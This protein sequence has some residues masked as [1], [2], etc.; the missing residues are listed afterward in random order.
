[1]VPGAGD[2]WFSY[3]SNNVRRSRN[4]IIKT[5]A[6]DAQAMWKVDEDSSLDAGRPWLWIIR[7]EITEAVVCGG[8]VWMN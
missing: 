6:G 3:S 8:G 1:M 4:D 7:N 5:T 2:R